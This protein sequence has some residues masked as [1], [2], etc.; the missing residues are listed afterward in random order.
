MESQSEITQTV[1]TLK[2]LVLKTRDYDMWSMRMKQY[3]THTDYALWEVIMNGDAPAIASAST[4]GPIPPKTTEQKL[5]RKNELKAKSTLLLAIP[6]ENL[7]KFHG[8]KDAKTLWE[9]IKTRFRGNKELKK[10]QKTILKQQYENF[11]ASRSEGLDKTYDRFQ[12]LISQLEIHVSTANSQGQASSSSYADDVMSFLSLSQSNS[13]TVWTMKTWS[14]LILMIL[15]RWISNVE[16]PANALVVQDGIGSSS[17]SSSDSEVSTCSKACLKSYESLKEHLDKQKEQLKKSN[18][19]IIGYQLGLES[20]EARIIFHQKNE[21]VYEKDIAFLKYDVKVRDNSITELKNQLAE[22]LREKDDLKLKLEKFETSSKKLTDLL[23]MF[24]SASD[25]SMN[26]IEEENNQV[27]DRFKKVEGYHAVPPHYT[28]N[29]M[30]SRPDLSF[31]GLDD[32]VYKTNVIETITSVS[33]NESTASKFSKDNLEQPKDVRPSPPIVEEWESN[34]DDDRVTRPSIE[35]QA[36]NLRKSQSPRVDKRNWNVL[37]TQKLRGSFEF[38]KKAH[39]VCGSLNH[40]IKDFKRTIYQR[41]VPKNSDFKE[42]VNTSKVNNVNTAGIKVVV[43]AVQGH[44]ENAVKSSACRIWRPIGKGNPQYALQDQGIFDSGCSRHMTGNKSYL[45]DYQDIDRGFVAFV[46]SP[47][48]GKITRKG[49]IRTGKLDFEDVYFVKELKFN[50]FSVSQMCDKK[51]SVLFTET[52]YGKATQ[53]L[54]IETNVNAV[55]TGQ[56]KASNHEYILLPFLTSDSQGMI[57]RVSFRGAY[58]DEDVGVEADLNNLETTM[59][60][61]SMQE[62]LLQFKLQKVWTLVDLHKGKRAIGTKWVYRNKKDERGIIVRNKARLVAQGYTQE[63]GIEYD[64]MDVKS[65]FLYGTIEEEV[66]VCQPPGFEDPEFP[67]KVYKVEKA[68]YGLHQALRAWYE[69][70]STYLIENGFRRVTIDKTLLIKK[71]KGDIL[72]V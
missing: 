48:G 37:I 11:T 31:A 17:S 4:E 49:K 60:I 66:Y 13:P 14:R 23:N 24:V 20:L 25:S 72:L 64:E 27:N 52:E 65:A 2:L 36:E 28:G 9:A 59:N 51:N 22:A 3:L 30:P 10:M 41:T 69:T 42:K 12:N 6:D 68:L 67:D 70:L 45:T 57:S 1:S 40:L 18:L 15:K 26:E 61:E 46:G 54:F 7:L 33:G 29:Y 8:I 21:A 71:D 55:Q 19:K 62:E 32:S 38:H 58:D 34:S 16:T 63:G 50:L 35:Q 53:S 44:E 39:F 56:E 5:A 43:S 47:K